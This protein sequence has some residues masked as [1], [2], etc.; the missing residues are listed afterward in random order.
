MSGP[1][2]YG[3]KRGVKALVEQE[4]IYPP[5]AYEQ[6]IDGDVVVD[7][8]VRSNGSVTD[9][10]LYA[11]SGNEELDK[12]ALRLFYLISWIPGEVN[13][14][15]VDMQDR[16]TIKFNTY[17]YDRLCRKRGY[18]HLDYEF[19]HISMDPRIFGETEL[20]TVA[21]PKTGHPDVDLERY[22][23]LNVTY[24][25]EAKRYNIEGSA[26]V[27]FVIEPHG[28]LTNIHIEKNL[29]G[30][31][32]QE[33]IRVLNTL[34]W[35]PAIKNGHAVRSRQFISLGFSLGGVQGFELLPAQQSG[36]MF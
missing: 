33:L 5:S 27:S 9:V 14:E 2:T 24:P 6:K 19:E 25:E 15:R 30:G 11:S 32:P 26:A 20:D 28:G 8:I 21:Q 35:T 10:K 31:C 22:L 7:F 16:W 1:E 4:M 34:D 23:I 3:G 29:G 13:G 12:E 36:V 18:R 17:K